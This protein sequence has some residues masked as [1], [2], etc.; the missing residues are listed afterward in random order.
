MQCYWECL[1]T[2]NNKSHASFCFCHI[3]N[4][5]RKMAYIHI[6]LSINGQD[7]S[8]DLGGSS[9]VQKDGSRGKKAGEKPVERTILPGQEAI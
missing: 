6:M 5:F 7:R 1:K 9:P 8:Q 2:I 3:P 4:E